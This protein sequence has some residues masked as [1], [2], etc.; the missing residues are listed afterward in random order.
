MSAING[1]QRRSRI[2]L[3][4]RGHLNASERFP[5]DTPGDWSVGMHSGVSLA[6]LGCIDMQR[7]ERIRINPAVVKRETV[8]SFRLSSW[9]RAAGEFHQN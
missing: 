8:S 2:Y 4:A 5:E 1:I 7:R 6:L 3:R 9:E